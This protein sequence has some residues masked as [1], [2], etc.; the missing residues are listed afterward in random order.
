MSAGLMRIATH[1][2]WD[3]IKLFPPPTLSNIET[4]LKMGTAIHGAKFHFVVE[5]ALT[6]A[7]LFS[8]Q[9]AR[10]RALDIFSYLRLWDTEQRNGV[11][12]YVLLADKAVE[13]VADRGLADSTT[14]PEWKAVC[15][16]MESEFR[17]QRFEIGAVN[18]IHAVNNILIHHFRSC[19]GTPI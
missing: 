19:A 2:F 7:P 13:V 4:A 17:D 6:G 18:G 3:G 10:E 15:S 12:I 5:S 8:G 9:T 14:T 1:A 11:L 16:A